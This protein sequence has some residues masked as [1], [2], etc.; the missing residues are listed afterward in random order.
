MCLGLS[1]IIVV[2]VASIRD[3]KF[4]PVIFF[5]K[6][7]RWVDSLACLEFLLTF[8]EALTF[9]DDSLFS[10]SSFDGHKSSFKFFRR[11]Q[12]VMNKFLG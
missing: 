6:F 4:L 9:V 3:M 7:S 12:D 2:H 11:L 1:C 10:F 5:C 8:D